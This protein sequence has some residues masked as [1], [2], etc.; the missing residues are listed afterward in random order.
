MSRK[1]L[2]RRLG[3]TLVELLVVIAIIGV[4]VALLLP[5]VQAARE[6]ARRMQC[7]NQLK[8]I[9]LAVHNHDD[10]F[11]V[12]P[13]GGNNGGITRVSGGTANAKSNPFQQAGTLFQILPYIEQQNIYDS[14]DNA[15][16]RRTPIKAYFCP[17]R[18]RP[19]TRPDFGNAPV[20]LNDYAIPLW[21]LENGGGGSTSG[22][23]G[24]WSDSN[25]TD[26]VNY[27]Y[28]KNTVFVRGGIKTEAF[29]ALRMAEITD[30]T[31]NTMMM[32]EKF[33][34][35]SRYF[36]SPAS[37]DPTTTWGA[38]GFTDTGYMNGWANWSTARCAIMVPNRD[39]A[40]ATTAWWQGFGSA[41]PNGI[42]AV[43]A[44]GSVRSISYTI[45][46]PIM[47]L[48]SRK[49]DGLVVDIGSF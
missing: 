47:V 12:F 11:L 5:A 42:N 3:F 7:Q 23:W 37:S 24:F 21:T 27:N 8:Q 19:L 1:S 13:T 26:T 22:C 9:G 40:Y 14:Q 46:S 6:A 29:P 25:A 10:S 35:P 45:P 48:I 39:K 2:S 20:A 49:D 4:L 15:L 34:D 17:S 31:S 43:F 38:L 16:I 30:G 33:V 18:R 36:P 44:D 28:Y 41:H 32:S